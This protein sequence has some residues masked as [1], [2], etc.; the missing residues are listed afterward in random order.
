[1]KKRI[2]SVLIT[3]VMLI[4]LVTVMSVSASAETATEYDLWVGGVQV[5]DANKDNIVVPGAIGSATYDPDTQTLTLN[6]FSYTGLG[7]NHYYY[8]DEDYGEHYYSYAAIYSKNKLIIKLVGNNTVFCE[9]EGA[10]L[11]SFCGVYTEEYGD[12]TICD[13]TTDNADRKSVV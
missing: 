5:T 12:L 8:Y 2:L 9:G 7:Y 4:G 10:G 11:P 1:M 13:D 6:N 3:L